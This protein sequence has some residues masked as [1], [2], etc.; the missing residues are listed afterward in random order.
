MSRIG[1]HLT[2]T[3]AALVVLALV[4][5]ASGFGTP[6]R[7]LSIGL[8]SAGLV[9]G[10]LTSVRVTNASQDD[11]ALVLGMNRLRAAYA[12]LDPAIVGHLVTSV[13]DDQQGV[14]TT[15]LMGT[16]R[17]LLSHPSALPGRHA[18]GRPTPPRCQPAARA[19]F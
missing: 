15:H 17:S 8:A 16:C 10:T 1:I 19:D 9:L 6:I 12:E 4:A 2:L 13:H 18:R 11:S 7:I 5:Q 14:M 3:S